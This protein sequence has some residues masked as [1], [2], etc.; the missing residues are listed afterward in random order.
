MTTPHTV[1][2]RYDV[3]IVGGGHNG[4]V[5][6]AYL[7]RAG[8]SV[9]LLERLDRTG[10][11]AVTAQPFLGRPT[12]VSRYAELVSLM[13]ERLMGELELGVRLVSRPVASYTPCERD[14]RHRGLLVENPEGKRTR[15]SFLELTDSSR[16]YDAWCS[17]Y[18]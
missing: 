14:G 7:A 15:L 11:A 12:K 18:S 2:G 17:F 6:A 5:A 13:P 3:A 9:I 10:G 8:L 16:E 4:L 1:Y